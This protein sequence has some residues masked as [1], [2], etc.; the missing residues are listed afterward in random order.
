MDPSAQPSTKD[1]TGKA[2]QVVGVRKRPWELR[3]GA[4]HSQEDPRGGVE[5][6]GGR[7][8]HPKS[9]R[10]Q[11]LLLDYWER[12]GMVMGEEGQLEPV[13]SAAAPKRV[14]QV[15]A[16]TLLASGALVYPQPRPLQ[17]PPLSPP[18]HLHHALLPLHGTPNTAGGAGRGDVGEREDGTLA[19]LVGG[20]AGRQWCEEAN[21]VIN[22]LW[23]FGLLVSAYVHMARAGIP[24]RRHALRKG[25]RRSARPRSGDN[26]RGGAPL[27]NDGAA[28][29][30]EALK[31]L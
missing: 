15:P 14:V 16:R 10:V 30:M 1:T 5:A 2:E 12:G 4:V 24:R 27:R 26:G 8:A 23:L 11:E 28:A 9:T 13:E 31:L 7:M 19:R 3:Q 25:T 22:T 18:R 29:E 20:G 17:R 6:T 21:R